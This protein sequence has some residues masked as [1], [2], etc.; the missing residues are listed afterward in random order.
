MN[1]AKT[2][3][4]ILVLFISNAYATSLQSKCEKFFQNILKEAVLLPQEQEFVVEVATLIGGKEKD[5][6]LGEILEQNPSHEVLEKISHSLGEANHQQ[7][8]EVALRMLKMNPSSETLERIAVVARQLEGSSRILVLNELLKLDPAP[9]VLRY[10][11]S[12]AIEIGG[13]SGAHI[14]RKIT[15]NFITYQESEKEIPVQII[16]QIAIA[17]IKIDGEPGIHFFRYLLENLK[18]EVLEGV[19]TYMSDTI[20]DSGTKGVET[21]F[22]TELLKQ[23]IL[24]ETRKR[25]VRHVA[26]TAYFSQNQNR[27]YILKELLENDPSPE[28]RKIIISRIVPDPEIVSYHNSVN[29][30]RS[31]LE[32]KLSS[33]AIEAIAQFVSEKEIPVQVINQIAVV[34]IKVGGEPGVHFFKY[35]LENLKPE[36]LDGVF[37]YI[38]DTIKDSVTKSVETRFLAELL[39][40]DI[41]PEVR[42]RIVQ[43]VVWIAHFYKD[44][45]RMLLVKDLLENDPSPEVRRIIISKINPADLGTISYSMSLT[46]LENLLEMNLSSQA[47]EAIA[48]F[49]NE[50]TDVSMNTFIA[51]IKE[52]EETFRYEDNKEALAAANHLKSLLEMRANSTRIKRGIFNFLRFR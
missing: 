11:I 15:D 42:K 31:L 21:R 27:I 2:V 25:I 24:P 26:E 36:V 12:A 14:L 43:R 41:L 33:Q 13:E 47:I 45:K 17:A 52:V 9:E 22:L 23:D 34:A 1:Y 10:I 50:N 28:V 51:L 3:F 44:K 8:K 6:L 5:R 19:F 16:N 30:L 4:L 48:Q 20:T 32:M 46:Y 35:L 39:K 29:Y 18:P 49:A 40:Q 38:S 7:K 37:K